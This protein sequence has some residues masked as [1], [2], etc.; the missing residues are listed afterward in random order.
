MIRVLVADDSHSA[1]LLLVTLL[2]SDPDVEVVGEVGDGEAAVANARRLKPDVITMDIEMPGV[3]GLEATARIMNESPTPIVVVSSSVNPRDLA[4]SFAAMKAGALVALAKP[5][6][7]ADPQSAAERQAFVSTV[8]A[9]SKVKVVRRWSGS[10]RTAPG[11]G[12]PPQR[13]FGGEAGEQRNPAEAAPIESL[14][15]VAGGGASSFVPSPRV[16]LVAMAA[17]TGGPTALQKVL[18][19]LPADFP[20]PIVLVQH[21]ARGFNAGFASWLDSECALSVKLATGGELLEPGTVYIA[22]DDR[23]LAILANRR[24]ELR[25]GAVVNGFKPSA[26]VLFETCAD[27]FGAALVAVIMTGMG[28]DG[29]S[30]LRRV[31]ATGGRVIAQDE[32]TSLIYGMPREAVIAGVVT[33]SLPL[34]AISPELEKVCAARRS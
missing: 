31:A 11:A 9:M 6:S 7:G 2:M 26:S 3:D 25:D 30:G 23:H 12:G 16:A 28:S 15:S 24:T 13:Q 8:K 10:Y 21:I 20:V 17:S 19:P 1:R 14:P 27:A 34:S 29:V 5:S 4:S 33:V 18:A 32:E 22:P